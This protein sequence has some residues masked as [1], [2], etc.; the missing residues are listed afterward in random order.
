MGLVAVMVKLVAATRAVTPY[1][2]GSVALQVTPSLVPRLE[3]Y[4]SMIWLLAVTAAVLTTTVVAAAATTTEPAGAAAHTA[5]DAELEQ[6]VAVRYAAA[7]IEP[8]VS[9]AV[10]FPIANIPAP[11]RLQPISQPAEMIPL[12]MQNLLV[13]M[14]LNPVVLKST[15]ASAVAPPKLEPAIAMFA[16]LSP[17]PPAPNAIFAVPSRDIAASDHPITCPLAVINAPP[18]VPV[19]LAKILRGLVAPDLPISYVASVK[20]RSW[21]IVVILLKS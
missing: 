20:I 18:K 5:G 3:S 11:P 15:C 13:L 19:P 7:L 14:V 1:K 6:L 4:W 17:A 8:E 16:V 9:P 10:P 21:M 12:V 2:A